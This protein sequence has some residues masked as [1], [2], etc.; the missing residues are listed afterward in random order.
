MTSGCSEMERSKDKQNRP[1]TINNIN[2]IFK[3]QIKATQIIDQMELVNSRNKCH[4]SHHQV[5]VKITHN[6]KRTLKS[7]DPWNLS[8]SIS[9]ASPSPDP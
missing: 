4:K 6:K 2:P 7:R 5:K 3:S 9:V 1:I 8:V